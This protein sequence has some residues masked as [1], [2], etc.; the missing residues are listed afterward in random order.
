[1]P[2]PPHPQDPHLATLAV[3]A[4]RPPRV[5]DAP[6]NSPIVPASSFV[7]G[8]ELE[9][10]RETGPTVAAFESALGTLEG[11]HAIGF[12]SGM[13]AA[14]AIM[15]LLEPGAVVVTTHATYTG[16]AVRL[17]ELAA[18]G[19]ITLVH[20]EATDTEALAK[21]CASGGLL[22][23]ESP[24]NPMLEVPDIPTLVPAA[25]ER[26]SR[27][28]VDNTFATPVLQRPLLDGV[29][30]VLH[31]VTKALSG[32]SDLLMGAVVVEN[33]TDAER[34]QGRRIFMGAVPSAFDAYLALRG[35]RT[36]TLRIEQ[37]Q[38]S[39]EVLA[40]R[41]REHPV[42]SRV[43]YPNFGSIISLEL[44][45]EADMAT[46]V[47]E[48]TQIWVHATSLG[49]VESLLERRRRWPHENPRVPED[50]IRLSVGI[51]YVEDLWTDLA[52]ALDAAAA[53]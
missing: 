9:Y 42:V 14:N 2:N 21:S 13:A 40:E 20:H 7:A 19:Q 22:W 26:G 36:L 39:A 45:G 41:L 8:G 17:R 15:D 3:E 47:C 28:V 29:D 10:A 48:A 5:P 44:N 49:G 1:V 6:L 12:S 50:L 34:L 31:S 18:K 53:S 46:R 4:G 16:V 38:R 33:A 35:M 52:A 43:H 27:V 37:A 30:F 32:H 25:H 23:L 51:E 11:G 24:T